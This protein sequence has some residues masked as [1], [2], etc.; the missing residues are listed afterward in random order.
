MSLLRIFIVIWRKVMHTCEAPVFWGLHTNMNCPFLLTLNTRQF[1]K[2][3]PKENCRLYGSYSYIIQR[4]IQ[5][6]V[7]HLRLSFFG[8]IVN[9]YK[10]WANY[11]CKK[12]PSS[13]IIPSTCVYHRFWLEDWV[14]WILLVLVSEAQSVHIV[15]QEKL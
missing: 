5:N 13:G 8:K 7:K 6:P 12:A 1:K 14:L 3:I 2:T 4:R 9:E 10:L 11:I 15:A